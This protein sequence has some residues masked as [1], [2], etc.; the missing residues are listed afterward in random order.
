MAPVIDL[1]CHVLPGIDDGPETIEG[2]IALA[3]A[4]AAAG[5][6]TIVAT[7]HVNARY[8]NDA[9]TIAR[10]TAELNRS[11]QAEGVPVNVLAGAEIA[12][13]SVVEIDPPQL[14]GLALGGGGGLP[15]GAPFTPIVTGPEN[16]V[17]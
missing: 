4:A 8:H 3:R 17:F 6:R 5:T 7:P 1:H 16:N 15:G 11:L 14:D 9:A 13:T 12:I 2:S 10:L